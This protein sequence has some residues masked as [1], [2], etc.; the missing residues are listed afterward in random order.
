MAPAVA[1][2][3]DEVSAR[4]GRGADIASFSVTRK[5]SSDIEEQA[6]SLREWNQVY[7]QMTPGRF[8]GALHETR[9]GGVQVFRESTNQAVHEAGAPWIGSRAI[10]LPLRMEGPA[11]FRGEAVDTDALVTLGS[12][13]ELDFYT[14]RDF[15]IL[16]LVVDENAL[17][18]HARQVEHCDL[19]VALAGQRVF[20]PGTA[21]LSEFRRLLMSVLQSLE[22]NPTALQYRQTQRVLEESMLKAVVAVVTDD[23]GAPKATSACAGRR[24]VVDAA[25]ALMQSCI[26]EPIT[27]A[28]LCRQLGVSRRTLQYSFQDVLDIN[29]VAFLRAMRLNGVRRDLKAATCPGDTVADIAAR[30]GFWHLGHFVTDFKRMFGELPSETLRGKRGA[31]GGARH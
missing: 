25:K 27:V 7:E 31:R 22:V 16:G 10:G 21:R 20:R 6:A 18:A 3:A 23:T 30:W 1:Y 15:E 2:V 24:H 29:P 13:D 5:T 11:R 9:F 17:D 4:H 14:P 8:V 28:D 26:A 19:A 12:A